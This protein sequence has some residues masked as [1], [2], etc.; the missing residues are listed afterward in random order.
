MNKKTCHKMDAVAYTPNHIPQ[1][2]ERGRLIFFFF[3]F[4]G[5][6]L[7][8]VS[9]GPARTT[10]WGPVSTKQGKGKRKRKCNTVISGFRSL[11]VHPVNFRHVI[12]QYTMVGAH[13]KRSSYLVPT[14]QGTKRGWLPVSSSKAHFQPCN[15]LL[16]CSVLY[17]FH[18]MHPPEIL[19]EGDRL[20]NPVPC[21]V[22][23]G[24]GSSAFRGYQAWIH[25]LCAA[26]LNSVSCLWLCNILGVSIATQAS[27]P[28]L[29]GVAS[30]GF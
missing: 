13:C 5:N 2:T 29:H 1:E 22:P 21:L 30:H 25:S 10:Q 24:V 23:K 18:D 19:D 17:R 14:I 27:L 26:L 7:Y 20:P 16:L 9:S 4:Q 3:K 8:V 6:L 11:L 12:R 15:F 28:Q